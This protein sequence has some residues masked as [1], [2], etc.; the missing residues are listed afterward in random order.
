MTITK[1]T[2]IGELMEKAPECA[3]FL[4]E[5]GMHCVG[6]PAAR[7]ESLEQACEVHGA[8]VDM[9]VTKINSFLASK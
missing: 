8:D 1:D 6:C 5:I 4:F 7:S 3:Q 2:I 9:L